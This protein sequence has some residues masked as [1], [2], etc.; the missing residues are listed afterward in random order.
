MLRRILVAD[1]DST[2]LAWKKLMANDPELQVDEVQEG[3]AALRALQDHN[4]SIFLMDLLLGGVELLEEI[5]KCNLSVTVIVLT[6]SE[7][8]DEAVKAM[9]LGAYDILTKPVDA[10]HL[11]MVVERVLCERSLRDE[12]P[13][14]REQL[15]K[16][17]AF[18][19]IISKSTRMHAVFELIANVAQTNTTILI[20]GETG[21][22]KEQI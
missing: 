7:S 1:S 21:T 18:R 22:G 10:Q 5:K 15:Q 4:Y 8:I 13:L 20:E 19:N 14:L 17:Y 3:A 11:R 2:C 12:V 6:G 16:R 9:R